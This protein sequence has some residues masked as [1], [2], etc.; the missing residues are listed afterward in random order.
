MSPR[1]IISGNTEI[2]FPSPRFASPVGDSRSITKVA[3]VHRGSIEHIWVA[4]FHWNK[5]DRAGQSGRAIVGVL[6]L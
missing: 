3:D 1:N 6:T 4:F 2:V 5:E